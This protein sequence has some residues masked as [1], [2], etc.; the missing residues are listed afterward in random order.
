MCIASPYL[1]FV[2]VIFCDCGFPC[3][4]DGID[5]GL[6]FPMGRDVDGGGNCSAGAAMFSKILIQYSADL[7]GLCSFSVVS[8]TKLWWKFKDNATSFS[9]S[10]ACTAFTQC[11]QS[12]DVEL[13]LP[14][15][16][17][18]DFMGMCESFS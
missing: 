10:I 7:V 16:R 2:S 17:D 15:V 1:S 11:F 14:S 3:F 18:S 9:L 4:Y 5:K 13:F 8:T 12:R 6:R